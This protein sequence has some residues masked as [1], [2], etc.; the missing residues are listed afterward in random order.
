MD[1]KWCLFTQVWLTG[2]LKGQQAYNMQIPVFLFVNTVQ[3]KT[4]WSVNT[5]DWDG[6]V[7]YPLNHQYPCA[8]KTSGAVAFYISVYLSVNTIQRD[9]E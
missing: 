2:P 3:S 6:G 7:D 9:I 1:P 5:V 4:Y 8:L